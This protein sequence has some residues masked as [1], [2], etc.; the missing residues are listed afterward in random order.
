M[1]ALL[2]VP[3]KEQKKKHL[4]ALE[5]INICNTSNARQNTQLV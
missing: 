5:K 2:L 4:T 3:R 1:M